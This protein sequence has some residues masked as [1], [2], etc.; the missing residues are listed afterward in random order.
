VIVSDNHK[1]HHVTDVQ[2]RIASGPMG[3]DHETKVWGSLPTAL[4]LCWSTVDDATFPFPFRLAQS[5]SADPK[6]HITVNLT[7]P[8]SSEE[9]QSPLTTK[10]LMEKAKR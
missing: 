10:G 3:I 4:A 9:N 5:Q 6:P 2:K 1:A 7:M 8:T